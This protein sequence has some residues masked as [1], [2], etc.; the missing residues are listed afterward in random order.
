VIQP[1][2]ESI[3]GMT[4]DDFLDLDSEFLE[5]ITALF[6][7]EEFGTWIAAFDALEVLGRA[8]REAGEGD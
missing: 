8:F 2:Y 4:D 5:I 1:D 6:S 3:L 7:A